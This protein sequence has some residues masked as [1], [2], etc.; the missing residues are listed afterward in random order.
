MQR[1]PAVADRGP[2]A[3]HC[4]GG[5]AVARVWFDENVQ[6]NSEYPFGGA[7]SYE[8][9]PDPNPGFCIGCGN[10]LP[11]FAQRDDGIIVLTEPVPPSVIGEYAQ[12][13][14][15]GLVDRLSSKAPVTLVGYGV[16]ERILGG[17]PRVWAG[18][19]VRLM[20]RPGWSR[21]CPPTAR[22]SSG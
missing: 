9:T 10:G 12:L 19:R 4:T 22:S 21:A 13:P 3:G 11:G 2:D 15:A 1:Q 8:G 14:S 17:G 18:L 16:Q 20:A 6:N 5:T 7:T